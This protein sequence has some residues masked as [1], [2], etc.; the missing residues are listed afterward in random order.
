[1][2]TFFD[3]KYFMK[4]KGYTYLGKYFILRKPY[5]VWKSKGSKANTDLEESISPY[6]THQQ[7][8]NIIIIALKTKDCYYHNQDFW[9][10]NDYLIRKGGE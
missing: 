9:K 3:I 5:H 1:M 7:K 4:E 8:E 2:R 10:F 6:F